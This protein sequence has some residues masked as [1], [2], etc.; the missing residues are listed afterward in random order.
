MKPGYI[1]RLSKEERSGC[2]KF[3]MTLAFAQAGLTP[4]NI[5]GFC[6]TA[7]VNDYLETAG[8]A[9]L[10]LALIGGIPIGVAAHVVGNRINQQSMK[11]KELQEK[12][13]YY[14]TA[15]GS[16]EHGLEAQ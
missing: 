4:Q 3:G 6:K 7:G 8:K 9:V 11:E 13:K 15:T 14:H 12:L 1:S 16:L 5:D 10:A 2:V